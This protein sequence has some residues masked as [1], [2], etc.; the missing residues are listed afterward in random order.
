MQVGVE[1]DHRVGEQEERVAAVEVARDGLRVAHAVV[2]REH[3]EH[4]LDLLRLALRAPDQFTRASLHFTSLQF[5][6]LSLRFT[7]YS[8]TSIYPW[9]PNI[10]ISERCEPTGLRQPTM[11]RPTHPTPCNSTHPYFSH[12]ATGPAGCGP[13]AGG[14]PDNPP[15]ITLHYTTVNCVSSRTRAAIAALYYCTVLS[16]VH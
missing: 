6:S 2:A 15:S 11:P 16:S 14:R 13:G 12:S 9:P 1:H 8:C 4:L 10:P 5:T 3:L 7:S